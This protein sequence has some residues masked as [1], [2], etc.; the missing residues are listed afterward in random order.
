MNIN[1]RDQGSV[2]KIISIITKNNSIISICSYLGISGN[3]LSLLLAGKNFL[4]FRKMQEFLNFAK[5][6]HPMYR[7]A[8]LQLNQI[9]ASNSA[10]KE[11]D[12]VFV[13]IKRMM[14]PVI[15]SRAI[16]ICGKYVINSEAIKIS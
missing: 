8:L 2:G 10:N 13:D 12:I 9:H 7:E 4:S 5:I 6:N 3:E 15:L 1:L 14:H 16:L 11:K